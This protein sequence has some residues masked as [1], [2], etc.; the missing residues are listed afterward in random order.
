[1]SRQWEYENEIEAWME[2]DFRRRGMDGNA[3]V[4]VIAG[5]KVGRLILLPRKAECAADAYVP[6][7]ERAEHTL[8]A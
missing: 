8:Y 7:L 4:P 1:M 5:G 6:E 2:Y 3:Y